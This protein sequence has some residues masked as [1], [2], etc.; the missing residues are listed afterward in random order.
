M[1]YKLMRNNLFA[2]N[3]K[4]LSFPATLS[5]FWT[6]LTSFRSTFLKFS[7]MYRNAS[8]P[9]SKSF[10]FFACSILFLVKRLVSSVYCKK[11]K[12][13]HLPMLDPDCLICSLVGF[14]LYK[15]TWETYLR[16]APCKSLVGSDVRF[17]SVEFDVYKIKLHNIPKSRVKLCSLVQWQ[18]AP[19]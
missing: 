10:M 13:H 7:M 14:H 5:F 3:R 18:L 19:L 16:Q 1:N 17:C 4:H 15:D 9:Q 11:Q 12:D 2:H 6:S 8:N